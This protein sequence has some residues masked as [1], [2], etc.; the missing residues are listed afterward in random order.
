MM[1]EPVQRRSQ[2][3]RNHGGSTSE[4][5]AIVPLTLS[6]DTKE[7]VNI[8]QGMPRCEMRFETADGRLVQCCGQSSLF[9]LPRQV[10]GKQ[11]RNCVLNFIA[12]NGGDSMRKV[13][14][15]TKLI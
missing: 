6:S 10:P 14:D 2:R 5:A 7:D 3:H 8:K 9:R 12:P 13:T 4:S 11:Q 15:A 1:G